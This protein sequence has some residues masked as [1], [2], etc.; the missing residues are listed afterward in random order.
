M[1][2][3]KLNRS[4]SDLDQTTKTLYRKHFPLASACRKEFFSGTHTNCWHV[5]GNTRESK[6]LVLRHRYW[7]GGLSKR[8]MTCVSWHPFLL[9]CIN[10]SAIFTFLHFRVCNIEVYTFFTLKPQQ[11]PHDI[12]KGDTNS[13]SN[14]SI[15]SDDKQVLIKNFMFNCGIDWFKFSSE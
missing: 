9:R 15:P 5:L 7:E 14:A 10:H 8:H 13:F 6:I 2:C 11:T 3:R 1:F 4:E 12:R